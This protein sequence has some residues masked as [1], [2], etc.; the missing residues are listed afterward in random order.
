MGGEGERGEGKWEGKIWGE[1]ERGGRGNG[2][3]KYGGR[4]REGEGERKWDKGEK[5]ELEGGKYDQKEDDNYTVMYMYTVHCT[6]HTHMHM[7]STVL[8]N[9]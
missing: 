8:D 9:P 2:R 1:R 6:T 4:V 3:E 5:R 7:Y